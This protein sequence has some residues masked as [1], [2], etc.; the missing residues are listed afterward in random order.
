MPSRLRGSL[1][2]AISLPNLVSDMALRARGSSNFQAASNCDVSKSCAKLSE[3][4]NIARAV[5]SE[6]CGWVSFILSRVSV[7]DWAAEDAAPDAA[8]DAPDA[9]D[10]GGS[11]VRGTCCS[12]GRLEPLSGGFCEGPEGISRGSLVFI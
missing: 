1:R 5:A 2:P 3:A 4:S 6:T 9:V 7:A 11:V 8:E 12:V 10:A